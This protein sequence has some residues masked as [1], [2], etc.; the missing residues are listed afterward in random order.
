M[1]PIIS[2]LCI[3]LIYSTSGVANSEQPLPEHP[4]HCATRFANVTPFNEDL[5]DAIDLVNPLLPPEYQIFQLEEKMR[6][7]SFPSPIPAYA[8]RASVTGDMVAQVPYGCPEIV[9]NA[10]AF[11]HG[12][13]QTMES[14]DNAEEMLAIL[15][16]H[17]IGHIANKHYGQFLPA[18]KNITP[19]ITPGIDKDIE[20]QADQFVID[21]L[22]P[23]I[24][25]EIPDEN[26][27]AHRI[28]AFVGLYSFSLAG[29]NSLNCFGCRPLGSV[30]IFWDHSR[31]H[32]NLELRLLKISHEV[33]PSE[34]SKELLEEFQSKRSS[35]GRARVW[36]VDPKLQNDG[37]QQSNESGYS[38]GLDL[39]FDI[40]PELQELMD[41]LSDQE[42]TE[43]SEQ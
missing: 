33:N 32:E 23:R 2:A 40:D 35:A 43:N 21:L 18:E 15:L 25:N 37:S 10:E 26:L 39:D 20:Q 5:K 14:T 8:G 19:N 27:A 41:S 42:D 1:R 7:K 16:L 9:F 34:T 6:H 28:M 13:Q 29:M 31:T 22:S 30:D 38:L 11:Y 3:A 36:Y 24:A 17:E 4:A 12:M